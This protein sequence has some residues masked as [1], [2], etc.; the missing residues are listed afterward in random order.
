MINLLSPEEKK[1]IRAAR[2]NVALRSQVITLVFVTFLLAGVYGTGYWMIHEQK[3]TAE[4]AHM[5]ALVELKQ[6]DDVKKI[7]SEYQSNLL[8]AKKILGNEVVF[9]QF[10]TSTA[11][12]LPPNT[13]ITNLSLTTNTKATT[14]QAAGTTT[15]DVRGKSYSDIVAMKDSFENS[16][17]FSNVRIVQAVRPDKIPTSGIG[18]VYPYEGTLELVIDKQT[19]ATP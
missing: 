6:F 11:G 10:L 14:G 16:S 13:I 15:I 18:A 3:K 17:L 8:V 2:V 19:K 12:I 4:V 1:Q 9:S 5:K 7:A